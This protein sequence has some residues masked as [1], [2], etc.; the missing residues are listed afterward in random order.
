M[1]YALR[2]GL[3]VFT[4]WVCKDTGTVIRRVILRAALLASFLVWGAG[5]P[6]NAQEDEEDETPAV[7]LGAGMQTSFLHHQPAEGDS[8]DNFR[9]N[10]QSPA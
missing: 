7:T 10:G 1:R 5:A 6:L 9:L 3:A 2:K 8:V 4:Q